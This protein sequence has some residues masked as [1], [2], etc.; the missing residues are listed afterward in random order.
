MNEREDM[1]IR[2]SRVKEFAARAVVAEE[3]GDSYSVIG[4]L[5]DAMANELA[6]ARTDIVIMKMLQ[7]NE[8]AKN[9]QQPQRNRGSV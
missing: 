5:L 6:F 3:A 9:R 7:G 1:R 2:L 4:T 8:S